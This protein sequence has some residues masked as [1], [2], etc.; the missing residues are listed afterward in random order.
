MGGRDTETQVTKCPWVQRL[1]RCSVVCVSHKGKNPSSQISESEIV[2]G[3]A[4]GHALMKGKRA[5]V[6]ILGTEN[7]EE[8]CPAVGGATQVYSPQL[9]KDTGTLQLISQHG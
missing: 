5:D 7:E 9:S 1:L 4:P 2:Q 3:D 8:A 6:P